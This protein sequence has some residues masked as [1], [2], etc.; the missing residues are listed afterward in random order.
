MNHRLRV[1]LTSC[2]RG[3]DKKKIYFLHNENLPTTITKVGFCCKDKE[4]VQHRLSKLAPPLHPYGWN[5]FHPFLPAIA[6]PTSR[7]ISI[8]L[9]MIPP[10]L[11]AQPFPRDV[12]RHCGN[13][14]RTKEQLLNVES[15]YL[16]WLCTPPISMMSLME[17]SY[18]CNMPEYPNAWFQFLTPTFK[19]ISPSIFLLWIFPWL[20]KLATS[21][22]TLVL[23]G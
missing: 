13:V 4:E 15:S 14:V 10:F 22:R 8:F 6:I 23:S 3:C 7:S 9:E 18:Q 2:P 16:K 21:L 17:F 19:F 5:N 12:I 20:R 11:V 1:V